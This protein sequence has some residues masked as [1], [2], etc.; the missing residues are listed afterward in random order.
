MKSFIRNQTDIIQFLFKQFTKLIPSHQATNYG[1]SS[2]FHT[3]N[4]IDVM[5]ALSNGKDSATD[6]T[7][8]LKFIQLSKFNK[9]SSIEQQY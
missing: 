9:I 4:I 2:K 6:A 7:G 5:A 1:R 3:C 8:H